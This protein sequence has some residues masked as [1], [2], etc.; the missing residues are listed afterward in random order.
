M[1]ITPIPR[2][3]AYPFPIEGVTRD[4]NGVARYDGLPSSLLEMLKAQVDAR[5]DTEAL[6]ELGGRRLT[7]RQL[8]DAAVL[9]LTHGPLSGRAQAGRPGGGALPGRDELGAGVLGG[10]AGGRDHG[11]GQHALGT[12]RNRVRAHSTRPR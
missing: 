1:A 6:V 7:Y 8:W 2:T 9:R 4:A 12:A 10:S 5:P 3:Q 11:R